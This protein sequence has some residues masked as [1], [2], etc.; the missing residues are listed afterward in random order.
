MT[1]LKMV[2]VSNFPRFKASANG[3]CYTGV[4]AVL[5]DRF[6]VSVVVAA[7]IE[8]LRIRWASMTRIHLNEDFVQPV[9]LFG[10][11]SISAEDRNEKK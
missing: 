3:I 1:S 6:G 2:K 4:S 7:N 5:E 9:A 8:D 10:L 11:K